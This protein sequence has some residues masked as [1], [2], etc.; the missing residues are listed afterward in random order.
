[1]R[2]LAETLRIEIPIETIDRTEPELSNLVK[3]LGKMGEAADKAGKSTETAG[4]RVS[5]F[6][7]SADKTQRTLSKWAKE[8]YQILLEAKDQLSPVLSTVGSGMKAFAGRTWSV[9]MK[10]IDLITSPVRGIINLL[11]NPIFQVGAVLGVSIGLKDTIDTYKDFE[12]SMSKVSAISGATGADMEK[13]TEKAKQ[14]GATTKFTATE[15]AEAFNYMAMAGWE[16]EDMLGGI[17]GILSL[18]AASGTDLAATSDIVT[19]ALTAFGMKANEAGH[20][21]DV[22]AAAS[23]K[24]NTNVTLMGETFK[25]AGA[26]AGTLG[27]SIED[28]A[29]A[30]GLMANAGIKGNMAGT[31][32]NSIFTRLSTNTHGA[33][34]ALKDMGIEYFNADGSARAFGDVLKELRDATANYTDEQKASLGNT[35]AGTYAQKGFLAMLNATTE[36]YE[37]LSKAVNNADG[38]AGEMA[39]IM[40]DNLAGSMTILQSAMDGVKLSFGERLSPYVKGL[41]EW[42]TE[43]MPEVEQALDQFMD[44][45]DTKAEKMQEK[46]QEMTGSKEWQNADFSGKVKIAWDEFIADPFSEWWNGTGKARFAEISGSIGQGIGTALKTGILTLLGFDLSDTLDE[47]AHIGASFA[48][49]FAEGFDFDTISKKLMEGLGNLVKN[50]GKLLPGGE[51]ADLSS[52]FSAALLMKIA[53]PFIGMGKGIFSLGRTLFGSSGGGPSMISSLIGST[54]NAM[55]GGSGLLGTFANI[56]YGLSGGGTTPGMYFGNAS[57]AMSGGAAALKS[58]GATA[59]VVAAGVTLVSGVMD[60]SEAFSTTDQ[61][62]SEAYAESGAWKMGGVAAGAA[63]G[64]ALGSV[65]PGLG[66]AVGAMVGAGVGGIAGW[67][68]GNKVKEEYQDNVEEMQKEAEKAQKVFEATGLSI[69]DITFKNEALTQAMKDSEVSA[70]D[71]ALMFQ[72]ECETVAKEAFGDIHLSLEEIQGLA[73]RITFGKMTKSIEGFQNAASQT[74]QSLSTLKQSMT[75]LDKWNWKA[76]LGLKLKK[77]ERESYKASVDSFIESAQ[78]YINDNHYEA[79]VALKLIVGSKADTSVIDNIYAEWGSGLEEAGTELQRVMDEALK[80]GVISGTDKIK[81]KI[82]G[83]NYEMDEASAIA[84]A[85]KQVNDITNKLTEAKNEATLDAMEM[86][87]RVRFSGAGMD[88]ES[89]AQMQEE[90]KKFTDEKA[91]TIE[92]AY[93]SAS[94]PLKLSLQEGGLSN[95]EAEAIQNQLHELEEQ[96]KEQMESLDLETRSFNLNT[97][98]DVWSEQLN[99]ILPEIEGT[100]AE[101]LGQAINN[102][103]IAKPDV[104]GWTKEDVMGWFGLEEL[105]ASNGE[106]FANIYEQLKQTAF[107][108]PEGTKETIIQNFK[109]QI[110]S[111]QEIKEAID[112]ESMTG[113]DWNEL[114]E[115]VTGQ[116]GETSFGLSP[117]DAA[118]P[119]AEYYGKYFESIKQSYSEALHNALENSTDSETLSS[120]MEQYITDATSSL[121]FTSMMEANGPISEEYYGQ[122]VEQ[123]TSGLTTAFDSADYS[124]VGS[125]AVNG[126]GNAITNVDRSGINSAID[127]LKSHTD[128]SIKSAF[129]AGI[130]TT[131]PVNVTFDYNVLNPSKKFTVSGNGVSK[132]VSVNVSASGGKGYAAGGY[133]SG[134]PQL[135]W[136][137][138]EGY[139]EFVI[140][141][142][143]SRRTRALELY[144]QAG[145]ALGVSAHAAGGYVGGSIVSSIASDS[146]LSSYAEQ[147][148]PWSNSGAE[149]NK[150]H[151]EAMPAYEAIPTEKKSDAGGLPVQVNVSMSP[152]FHISSG[153]GQSEEK[154]MQVIRRHLKEMVDELGGELAESLSEAFSNMPL[155]EA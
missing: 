90:I 121:D 48:K 6:D 129:Q 40:M 119:M 65:I 24:S 41:A 33:A 125:N 152:E 27:Y 145:T 49:G 89:Y 67:I 113:N 54:G 93:V 39:E 126:V 139:G 114:I 77:D 137:A 16:T 70:S 8:K 109:E 140:P 45:F 115:S 110:P 31:A 14:M 61:D 99:G 2:K 80:D 78:S 146:V 135:S 42:L 63:A 81:V 58:A 73:Q 4:R 3:K 5:K 43:Q 94:I 107:A 34:D 124:P 38:A 69:E 154:V 117:E 59:G 95:E 150:D 50:A 47:G 132:E 128:S 100:T 85:Q 13:L 130:T 136:L 86:K 1:M 106:A 75:E 36:D 74:G 20:F 79:T 104:D 84:E 141:T 72:E 9:T 35:I 19:D 32:L 97:I 56:G 143:P 17:E 127:T 82:G 96:Y 138:E 23:S 149:E 116:T 88:M 151:M 98:A 91:Q 122:L 11:K 131:M 108:V 52:V 123:Y 71:F 144:E 101:K 51:A 57:G 21:A 103:L 66:T 134:G 112:W 46:F 155:K 18:A 12:A 44:W 105:A 10:A 37:K 118:K 120:F 147:A 26:M 29:L 153:D 133:I 142:N 25:Y 64:A 22:L 148:L 55:V 102:A 76:N 87:Y 15:S 53:S 92:D 7:E 62:K 30:T 28:V 83:I 111:V 68:K 60:F